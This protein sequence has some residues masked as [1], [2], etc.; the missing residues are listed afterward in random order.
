[1]MDQKVLTNN[2]FGRPQT[3]IA[4]R[5]IVFKI[6][7]TY[8]LDYV[9]VLDNIQSIRQNLENAPYIVSP[10][11]NRRVGLWSILGSY[12]YIMV[13]NYVTK[14]SVNMDISERH[15]ILNIISELRYIG[16]ITQLEYEKLNA[17]ILYGGNS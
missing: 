10:T 15:L 8:Y 2:I 14:H 5:K 12:A 13:N 6:A 4:V 11:Y 7:V 3:P 16:Y 9:C 17:L 1:M